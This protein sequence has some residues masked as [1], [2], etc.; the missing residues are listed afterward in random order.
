VK[1]LILGNIGSGKTSLAKLVKDDLKIE[2]IELDEFRR[3]YA[4]GTISGEYLSF[5]HFFKAVSSHEKCILEFTGA[6]YH[7]HAIRKILE[8]SGTKVFV[9]ILVSEISICKERI[10]NRKREMPPSSWDFN[11]TKHMQIIENELNND[12]KNGFWKP[13]ALFTCFRFLNN[14]HN[15]LLKIKEE[16][17]LKM[18]E[19]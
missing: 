17:L 18:K 1:I 13:S 8:D 14:Q 15:T 4:D 16:F 12:Y 7:K 6:G 19:S 3:E 5:Y 9:I 11:M 2:F 10:R